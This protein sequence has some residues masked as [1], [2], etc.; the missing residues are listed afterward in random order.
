MR[1]TVDNGSLRPTSWNGGEDSL[2]GLRTYPVRADA[3][4]RQSVAE[5][6]RPS[7]CQ[8]ITC[9]MC[10]KPPRNTVA[11]GWEP[12]TCPQ[13][14]AELEGS[15]FTQSW[16]CWKIMISSYD[17]AWPGRNN[18]LPVKGRRCIA[19]RYSMEMRDG[20]A[21]S[22][23]TGERQSVVWTAVG[24]WCPWKEDRPSEREQGI[25]KI[26]MANAQLR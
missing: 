7:W 12:F 23:K 2:V 1:S 21:R 13:V 19:Y 9:W 8:R 26:G 6:R 22:P 25:T 17:C 10:A 4:C 15:H 3:N 5:L 11:L 20:K 16:D 14:T 24:R 18:G